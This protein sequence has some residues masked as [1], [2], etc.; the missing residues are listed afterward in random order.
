MKLLKKLLAG[1]SALVLCAGMTVSGFAGIPACA[2]D[3]NNDDWIH[4]VGSR[5]YDKDGNEVWITGANWF[6]FNCGERFPHGLWS[7]DV[8][9]MISTIADHGINCLRL[10]I[11]TELLMDW[12]NG[13]DDSATVAGGINPKNT[14]DYSFNPELCRPDGSGMGSL[15]VFEVIMAKCKKYGV[16]VLVDVHS[17]ALHNSGHNYN[18]WYYNSK[19]GDCD[20]MAV[21]E[22]GTKVTTEMWQ[23]SLVWLADRYKNDDT[24]IAYDLKNEP[25]GKGQEGTAAAKWDGSTDENNWAYASTQCALAML[26]KN[27]NALILIE[28][29]EQYPKEGHTWGEPDSLTNPPYYPGWWGGQFRGVREYPI[30][31]GK[32]QSQLVYSPHD[33]GPGVYNQTWF[34]KDF[35]T[36]SLLDDY[37]YDTWAFI[38]AEDIAPL[39]IGEWG[40]FMDGAEN[41]KWMTLL[42]DYM[43][44]NHINHT[45]W[46]INPNSGDTG[47]LLGYDWAT[48]DDDKY[49]LFEPSLWQTSETGKYISL[50]HAH[51]LGSSGLTT[52]EY[53]QSYADSEGSN[54]D[55]GGKTDPLPTESKPEPST[56]DVPDTS[57]IPD[58]SDDSTEP[59][60]TDVLWGDANEDGEVDIADVVK[61]NRVYVGVDEVTAQGLKNADV[62]LSGKI[63]LAD[64]MNVLKLLVHLLSESDFPIVAKS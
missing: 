7:A 6:G 64:S 17:P 28:G 46:C 61:M 15:E 29:V 26:E 49:S 34:Q 10:P 59:E 25:H 1:V 40:G 37:W 48:W 23:D 42:R 22:D 47:G 44:D 32:Y 27:P 11:A 19:A 9:A 21:T 20:N 12:M 56:S 54:L 58:T 41:Q 24:L 13:V 31:L 33:Y 39:L 36:Q 53:Y 60:N 5:L 52:A 63:E 8:D 62:D 50:D 43:I 35:T 14:P 45:F 51:K 38:N 57:D 4:A 55:A 3:D 2:V 18:V 30:D 16:K